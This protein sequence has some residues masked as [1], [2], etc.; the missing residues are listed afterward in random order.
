MGS[1]ILLIVVVTS[2]W[3]GFDA[4]QIGYDKKDVKGMASMGP[5]S[6]FLGGL[7]VWIFTF[8]L[9]LASRSKLK[10]A[11]SENAHR[12]SGEVEPVATDR[13]EK[14]ALPNRVGRVPLK[15]WNGALA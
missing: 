6:W 5:V 10:A 15:R 9:Y 3:M 7:V 4:H 14:K 2:V 13:A 8:P 12:H 1:L 11:A